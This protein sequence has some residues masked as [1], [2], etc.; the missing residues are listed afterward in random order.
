MNNIFYGSNYWNKF[1]HYNVIGIMLWY[2]VIIMIV[3]LL[4]RHLVCWYWKINER[5]KLQEE[6]NVTLKAILSELK[7][8]NNH[9][10]LNQ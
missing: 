3:I 8:M 4:V 10:G 2:I 6:M 1:S 9:D 7:E 5:V